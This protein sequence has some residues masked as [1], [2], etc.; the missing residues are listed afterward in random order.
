MNQQD[1]FG[2]ET[3]ARYTPKPEHV[4]NSLAH[5]L[6]QMRA[7]QAWPWDEAVVELHVER[8]V[9]YLLGLL[10]DAAEAEDWRARFAKETERLAAG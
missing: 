4:R 6:A 7:A 1:L 5:L 10:T 3:I 9:P 2:G 8:T